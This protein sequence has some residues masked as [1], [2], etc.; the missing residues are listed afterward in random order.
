MCAALLAGE[1]H[2]DAVVQSLVNGVGQDLPGADIVVSS[3]TM[4]T[5][6]ARTDG[7]LAR[8]DGTGAETGSVASPAG[9][10][11]DDR[12]VSVVMSARGLLVAWRDAG[13]HRKKTWKA[14]WEHLPAGPP[15]DGAG[16]GARRLVATDDGT[17]LLVTRGGAAWV[18]G[19]GGWEREHVG[20]EDAWILDAMVDPAS[21]A[22]HLVGEADRPR[23]W[24]RLRVV[25]RLTVPADL[26]TKSG[27][28][29]KA[30]MEDALGGRLE[31]I[32]EGRVR[33]RLESYTDTSGSGETNLA[34]SLER[35]LALRR[36]LVDR[37]ADE[38]HV[39]AIGWGENHLVAPGKSL[40]NRRVVL[41]V[42][43]PGP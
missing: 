33:V 40:K 34:I 14:A 38:T 4:G 25:E 8:L 41:V 22:L 31:D 6:A 9:V 30:G 23:V 37:G 7:T 13:V 43:S 39:D 18:L 5:F 1:A 2:P 21:G 42:L 19:K 24:T 16:R 29:V 3:E 12:V 17:H 26:F 27:K 11:D 35:A 20:L 10:G 36:W 32:V 28:K 15:D